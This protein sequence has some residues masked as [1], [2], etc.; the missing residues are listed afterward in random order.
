MIDGTI[1]ACE[2][3]T[4]ELMETLHTGL[5]ENK[6]WVMLDRPSLLLFV[7]SGIETNPK[8]ATMTFSLSSLSRELR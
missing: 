7:T 3:D 8:K 2:Y 5:R 1:L 6:N 4:V